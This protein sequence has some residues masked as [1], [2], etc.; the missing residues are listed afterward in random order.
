MERDITPRA[1]DAIEYHNSQELSA[2]SHVHCGID[3]ESSGRN[4]KKRRRLESQVF[5]Y[6][7]GK[8]VET[9]LEND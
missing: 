8:H 6:D 7:P 9:A 1:R 2:P 4:K 5:R 3:G